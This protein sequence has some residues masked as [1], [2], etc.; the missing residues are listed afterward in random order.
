M[1]QTSPFLQKDKNDVLSLTQEGASHFARL[2]LDCLQKEYPNK[3]NQVLADESNLKSPHELHPAFYGC[4]DWHSSVHGHWMLVK[5]LQKFPDI[6]EAN[7]IR[8]KLNENL[9]TENIQGEVVYFQQASKSWERMYGWSWLMKLSEEL[10][11]GADIDEDFQR[12]S[13]TYNR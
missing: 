4:F 2:A 11:A 12:W 3:L 8:T 5:L 7:E 1:S 6:P 10:Y 9:T 13:K